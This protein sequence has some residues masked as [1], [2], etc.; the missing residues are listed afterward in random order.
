[1]FLEQF[2]SNH[3][4]LFLVIMADFVQVAKA[5][6][7]KEGRLKSVNANGEDVTIANVNGKYYAIAAICNH[8]GWDLAEGELEG[9]SIVCAGHGAK[10]N[11]LTGEA[12][13]DEPLHPEPLYDIKVEE[14]LIWTKKRSLD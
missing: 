6:D 13:F 9:E 12:E 14:D 2:M 10:W 8:A 1:M 11:L 5:S 4:A 7:I 3:I